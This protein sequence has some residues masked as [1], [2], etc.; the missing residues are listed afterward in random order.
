[1]NYCS[2][3]LFNYIMSKTIQF[4]LLIAF[5]FLGC[6][7]YAQTELMKQNT[8]TL[9]TSVIK[10]IHINALE[11]EETPEG[12]VRRLF[13]DVH[14]R[15]GNAH[16]WCDTGYVYPNRQIMAIGNVQLLQDDSIR[17]FSD[18]LFYDGIN[19]QAELKQN[20]V[21]QDSN[22]TMFTDVLYY[23]LSSKIARYPKK[24]LIESDVAK[25][26]SKS[27][28]YDASTS[29][30]YF[31]DSVTITH[32][33]YTLYAVDTLAFDTQ[34]EI[35]YFHGPT[36][37]YNTERVIYC[38]SGYYDSPSNKAEFSQN[39]FYSSNVEG[40]QENVEAD[41]ILYDG[42]TE[43]YQILGNA[44]FK[45]ENQEGT[46]D[47]ILYDGQTKEYA[48]R[49]N[50]RFFNSSD[51]TSNQS[52]ESE[53]TTY[54]PKT[55]TIRFMGKVK[56][57]GDGQLLLSD[58]LNYDKDTKQGTAVGKVI[59]KD[60]A[61]HTTVFSGKAFYDNR[62]D[63]LI[64][65]D[66]PVMVTAIDEDSLW[67][68]SDTLHSI[69][70]AVGQSNR[71]VSAY[72]KVRIFKK[73]MQGICDSLSYSGADSI[74]HM[75]GN[76]TLWIDSVQFR[77][78]TIQIQL[79]NRKIRQVDM[80]KN[81]FITNTDE[82]IYFNQMKGKTVTAYFEENRLHSMRIQGNAET[83]YYAKDKENRFL[84]VNDID[85]G[86]MAIYFEDNQVERIKF[87]GKPK[88]ALYPMKQIKHETLRL[89]GFKWM[90]EL[91]P[92]SK[93]EIYVNSPSAEN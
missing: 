40:K 86:R 82:G 48:F 2:I 70:E 9:D 59:F 38:E 4:Y 26:L 31:N 87:I 24:T 23:D 79:E 72:Q 74:F 66:H 10:I 51:T 45:D 47:S 28:F 57:E 19:R 54:D 32:P 65:D 13:G 50:P 92:K 52:I 20:V 18:S 88:A 17:I 11:H 36:T 33:E 14:L 7:V 56:A 15:Q 22:A 71:R 5:S 93:G 77:A 62:N 63:I 21:L 61:S 69:S 39:A 3:C 49:G 30:A 75:Y 34:R 58:S 42:A 68:S 76:P 85:C 35:A 8:S 16:V 6:P 89:K 84:G 1:M 41:R 53:N 80:I 67:I 64:A 27:G 55:N 29:F 37:I 44:Y 81:S 12:P 90:E 46:A 43:S 78:D 83:V 91:R 73:D 60:S 25:L